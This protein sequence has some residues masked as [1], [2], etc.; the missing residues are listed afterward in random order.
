ME[1]EVR[2]NINPGSREEKAETKEINKHRRDLIGVVS[3]VYPGGIRNTICHRFV[4]R[5]GQVEVHRNYH[6][7]WAGDSNSLMTEHFQ[8]LHGLD[9][10]SCFGP[11]VEGPS[12]ECVL[13]G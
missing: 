6:A 13:E 10:H 12:V 4:V 3:L 8:L 1:Y 5:N 9:F 7:V 11:L 2:Q